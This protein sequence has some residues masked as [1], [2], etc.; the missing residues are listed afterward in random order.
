MALCCRGQ[1]KGSAGERAK[2]VCLVGIRYLG[3]SLRHQIGSWLFLV[4]WNPFMRLRTIPIAAVR[5]QEQPFSERLGFSG[6]PIEYFPP[7]RFY[8]L[9]LADP[10]KAHASFADWLRSCLL[11]L[12]AWKVPQAE[13]GWQNGSLVRAIYEIHR[14]QGRALTSFELADRALIA[15]AIDQR[16]TY[17]LGLLTAIQEAGFKKSLYPPIYCRARRD[18]FFLENGH[19]RMSVLKVLGCP[20]VDVRVL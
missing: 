3:K 1:V 16:V 6:K 4:P 17:Y 11:D 14:E 8:E 20:T 15:Q 7:C 2:E 18:L 10:Q 5:C 9:A 19:H 13:G 12:E